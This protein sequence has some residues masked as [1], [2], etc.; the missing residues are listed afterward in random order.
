M[1]LSN[2]FHENSLTARKVEETF[3]GK[4]N[5]SKVAKVP[6]SEIANGQTV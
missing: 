2:L 4:Y 1:G 3:E 5:I 6:P